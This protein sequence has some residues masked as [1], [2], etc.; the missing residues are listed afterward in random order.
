[1]SALINPGTCNS[2]SNG[3]RQFSNKKLILVSKLDQ[4]N[5][6]VNQAILIPG[7]DGVITVCSDR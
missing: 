1:M 4:F 5:D 2:N 6:D 7:V 3:D